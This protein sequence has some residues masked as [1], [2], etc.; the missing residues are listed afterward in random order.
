MFVDTGEKSEVQRNYPW[1][2]FL[3]VY[4]KMGSFLYLQSV[5]QRNLIRTSVLELLVGL[6]PPTSAIS[7]QPYGEELDWH[8]IVAVKVEPF[9]VCS[10]L[11]L[12]SMWCMVW[13]FLKTWIRVSSELCFLPADRSNCTAFIFRKEKH[14]LFYFSRLGIRKTVI[15]QYSVNYM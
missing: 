7:W 8:H 6:I 12:C 10:P 4:Y 11:E 9:Y 2:D 1:E 14:L 3:K 13:V 5:E 15:R